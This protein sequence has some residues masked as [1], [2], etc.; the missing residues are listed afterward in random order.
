MFKGFSILSWE[1]VAVRVPKVF[2]TSETA[3]DTSGSD[4]SLPIAKMSAGEGGAWSFMAM[5]LSVGEG[6]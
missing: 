2:S 4:N 5:A 6:A 3:K 1:S